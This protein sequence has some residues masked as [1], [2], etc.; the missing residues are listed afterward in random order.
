MAPRVL[1]ERPTVVRIVTATFLATLLLT[2]PAAAQTRFDVAGAP[3][4]GPSSFDRV[5]VTR[6]GPAGARTVLV[7]VPGTAGGAG[8]FT[9]VARDIVARVPGL[10]VWAVE[11]REQ[12]LEDTTV[13]ADVLA[14]RRTLREAFDHYLGWLADPAITTHYQP[15]DPAKL[16]FTR[17]WGLKV[18]LDDLHRV[19]LAARRG[20][21]RVLLGGHSLGA[22]VAAAYA[23]WDFGGRAGARDLSGLVLID[24]GLLGSFDAYGVTAARKAL[25]DLDAGS[26]FLDLV[27]VGLPW[28][29]GAFAEVGGLA[30]RLDPAGP[31]LLQSFPLLPAQFKAP[32]PATNRG[33]LGYAFDASTSPKALALI[34]VRAGS[35]GAQGDWVDGE[36]SPIARVAEL[37]GQEPANAVE[38][39]FP[40]RL[41]I[42]V[43]GANCLCRSA[44]TKLLGL[45]TWH[46]RQVDVPLY[47]FQTSLTGGRV[48]RGARTL[49]RR[50]G[51]GLRRATIV[52]ASASTSHLD[53][54][55][56]APATNRFLA[57]VAPWLRARVRR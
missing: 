14:G 49:A 24:G 39:Y 10:Q 45:R 1:V 34:Q 37:F 28:A 12:A 43:N 30:A 44:V 27:G 56:A 7:L 35:L 31:S 20:G 57:T 9:L 21:R 52:D 18:Q 50:S 32:V 40:R 22:S 4:P 2:V 15:Q 19:V 55:T 23:T 8:D 38:W 53:P 36:V 25:A 51:I 5:S 6:I 29:A 26:P 47:A 42:D 48:A 11:R 17:R 16:A 46:L 3:A 13:F 33:Q 41:S 54:L